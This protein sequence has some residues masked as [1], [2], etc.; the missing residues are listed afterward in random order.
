[1]TDYSVLMS[2]YQAE[3]AEYLKASIESMLN[4][5]HKTNDF[6]LVCDGPL[7]ENL[8]NVIA[9]FESAHPGLFNVVRIP[10]NGGLAN[11][12]NAG[13]EKCKNNIVARMD[14]DDISDENRIEEE[15]KAM[16]EH[17]ADIVGCLIDEFDESIDDTLKTR[18]VPET[19]DEIIAFAKKRSPFNHPSVI[20]KK[21]KVIAAGKYQD[22]QYF[23]DYNLWITMLAN[24]CKGYNV[25]KVLLHM[26]AGADLYKRRGGKSYLSCIWSFEK[27][28]K[29]I[30][31]ISFGRYIYSATGRTIVS[32]MPNRSRK[33]VY[34]KTLRK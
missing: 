22:Y 28:M 4:Q 19:N 3:K 17:G 11:A 24:G 34:N 12:L 7:N 23:E 2:V 32:L 15:L 1:M 8:D 10:E 25:Q 26:R 6:V 31:F 33:A 30:G 21:D 5:T 16:E 18:I 9:D 29:E 13:I 20:Y 14:S 27:N